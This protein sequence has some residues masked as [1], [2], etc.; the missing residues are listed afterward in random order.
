MGKKLIVV[1]IITAVALLFCNITLYTQIN[2]MIRRIN[3][4]YSSNVNLSEL[5]DS[6]E[7]VQTSMYR[8][9]EIR[10]Y[11]ALMQYYLAAEEYRDLYEQLSSSV[12]NSPTQILEKNIRSMSNVFLQHADAAITAKRGM[13]VDEYTAE[14]NTSMRL[15]QFIVNDLS[16]LNEQL[17]QNN[18]AS[19]RT[20]QQAMQFT[21]ISSMVLL[22]IVILLTTVLVVQM[23]NNIVAPLTSLAHTAEAVGEGNL[24]LQVMQTEGND[25]IGIL[26]RTF[27][28]MVTSLNS[29]VIRVRES[30]EKEQEMMER[31]LKMQAH[32]KEAQLRFLQAQIN[33]HFLFNSLNAGVQLAEMED[34]EKTAVFLEHMA[35]FFRYNVKKGNSD[36][37]LKE[38]VTS[39]ENYIYILN[40]RFSGEI[41]FETQIDE[42][43]LRFRMPSMILQPIV[44]N[45]VNH[46][47]RDMAGGGRILL[48]IRYT[49]GEITV[50]IEDN[51][52]GMSREQ[53]EAIYASS[54]VR[55]EKDSTGIGLDNV[56]S[57]LSLYYDREDILE[58]I[59]DG[60]D[61]GTS[62]VLHLPERE[63]L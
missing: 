6:L 30:A 51:G 3:A 7:D 4:V 22:V 50:R 55:K 14:Y 59:S 57:R 41:A 19:Y 26:T 31:E 35:D 17:F 61:T 44:E 29:Y 48:K 53:I 62:V 5:S 1:M 32:L 37:T 11:S 36:T 49:P 28:G 46:G 38:E 23:T 27:N 52:K 18:A 8:Y 24:E 58:I 56:I 9:L 47:I 21:E 2:S 34:D 15:Y 60:E 63:G 10:D 20:L 40:V 39:V 12:T 13:N 45:A 25:E 54:L 43:A 33:P 16:D 42:E